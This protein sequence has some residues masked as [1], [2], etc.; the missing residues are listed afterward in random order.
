M[1]DENQSLPEQTLA[2]IDKI[3]LPIFSSIIMPFLTTNPMFQASI[4]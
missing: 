3:A 2:T 4:L 1:N